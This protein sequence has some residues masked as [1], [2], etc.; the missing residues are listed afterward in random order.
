MSKY[1]MLNLIVR[2]GAAGSVVVAVVLFALIVA[3]AQPAMGWVSIAV[4]LFF[5]SLAYVVGR[6]YVELVKLISEMLMPQ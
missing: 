1:P 4:A 3:I 2:H 6:S 5:A